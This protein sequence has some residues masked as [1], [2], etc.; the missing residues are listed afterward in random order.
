MHEPVRTTCPY[1]GV[2]CGLLAD[3]APDGAVEVRGDPEHPA[4]YGRL[5]SKGSA[6]AETLSLEGR[7]LQPAIG[8]NPASWDE[9]LDLVASRFMSAIEEHGPDSVAF[10]VS[11]QL[12]TEDYYVANKLM[13]GFIGS[14]NIDTNSRLCMSSPVAGHR[15]AFGADVVPGV[16]EDLELA[17]LVIL[18]GSNLA[19]C[20]PVLF[21][22][23]IAAK[24]KRGTKIAV[25]DPRGTATAEAASLHLPLAPGS[26]VMLFNGLL[27]YLAAN[28]AIAS[29]YVQR[30]T[31][32]LE[33]ALSC[34]KAATIE[35]V[36]RCTELPAKDV[37]AFYELFLRFERTVTVYSQGVNQSTAG[38]DKVNAI[39]NCHLATGRIGRAGMGPFSV[40]GQPNAMGGREV[41]GLAHML[42]AHMDLGNAAHRDLVRR[43]WGAPRIAAKPGLK[44]IDLFRA[45]GLGQIKALWIMA[46]N[47]AVSLP[48]GDEVRAALEHCPFVV[49]SDITAETGTA[50][51][52]DVL[53]PSLGWGE[54]EGTVTNSER[55]ISRQRAFLP[56]P[57]DARADW[58]Q[59]AEVARRMGFAEAFPYLSA[60]EIFAEHAGLSAFENGGSRAF[61]IGAHAGIAA[62]DY[63]GLAPFQWPQPAG[64]ASR[65]RRG[66]LPRADSSPPTGEGVSC[67][68]HG[69]RQRPRRRLPSRL[70]LNTGRIRDQWHTMTRT[71]KAPRLMSHAPEPFVEIHP[72]DAARFGLR[73]GGLAA[74]RSRRG[75]VVVRVVI[76]A[77]QK[78]G[79]VFVPIH[80]TDRYA[81]HGR[82]DALVEG[83]IDPI[84]GQPELKFTPVSAAP[85]PAAWHG[86]A[87]STRAPGRAG[88]DYWA[89]ARTK[90]GF[91]LEFAGLS[92]AENWMALARAVL[93]LDEAADVLA[94]HDAGA[95]QHRFAAF[96]KDRLAGALFIARD[97]V[98]VSRSWICGHLGGKIS[99]SRRPASGARGQGRRPRRRPGH[100][101]LLVLRS[102]NEANYRRSEDGHLPR[103][104]ADRPDTARGHKLRVMHA[105][106]SEDYS[107]P[108]PPSLTLETAVA[109]GRSRTGGNPWQPHTKSVLF[110]GMDTRLRAC[111]KIEIADFGETPQR[112]SRERGNPFQALEQDLSVGP[113]LRGDDAAAWISTGSPIFSHAPAWE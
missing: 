105:G 77:G 91:R 3:V 55:R 52:A 8:G 27:A 32:G 65:R 15:R 62:R 4:N 72:S 111:E 19:W 26:D 33:E 51:Y 16:Y 97:P 90:G 56:A 113:C 12:L 106:D 31:S 57:G 83:L 95:G 80:W 66:T 11:G 25:I 9:A 49:V 43:Y 42:A 39:I 2:G 73:D 79:S 38:T 5:C 18:V 84:S 101:R 44:A 67:P 87:V 86:F 1:C 54:K 29:G 108:R 28:G 30:H 14:A 109:A 75:E 92:P 50:D 70:I 85:Y 88:L 46:T 98:T 78:P 74:V 82:V 21:Q 104:P 17:D 68:R 76:S 35:E 60:A 6:L 22:R 40:T 102:R 47:P 7:L 93:G 69:A 45:V 81:S 13:K 20:H 34:A 10:Y 110:A 61:D 58:W 63:A 24:E 103:H 37:L 23:L 96:E 59:L 100:N 89:L 107:R 99:E 48:E 41:G 64:A 112:H 94:Y 36:A 71:A 53:L